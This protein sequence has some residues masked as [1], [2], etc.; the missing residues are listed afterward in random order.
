MPSVGVYNLDKPKKNSK[1]HSFGGDIQ[2]KPAFEIICGPLNLDAKCE[3]CEET[4]KNVYWKS[5]KTHVVLCRPCYNFRVFEIKIKT[6][7][8]IEKMRK[9]EV[10]EKDFETKRYCDFY[11]EHNKTSAAVRLLSPK[12]FHNRINQENFLN[13]LFKY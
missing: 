10:M 5:R 7:G 2:I 4:P 9:L 1:L 6:R 8:I 13:T 3:S 11:H 12:D